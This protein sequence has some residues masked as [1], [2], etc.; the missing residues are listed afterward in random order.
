MTEESVSSKL[1]ELFDLYK[2]GAL[3]KE[4]YELLKSQIINQGVVQPINET[5]K[6]QEKDS[7]KVTKEE[8]VTT[9]PANFKN[10]HTDEPKELPKED[11]ITP[12]QEDIK[13]KQ[14]EANAPV[15]VP[16]AKSKKR[17]G[18]VILVIILLIALII[19]SLLLYK[20]LNSKLTIAKSGLP[21]QN[22]QTVKD[23]D[24]NVYHT[25]TIGSQVWIVENLRT[26]KYN[27]GTPIPL[28]TQNTSWRALTTPAYCW[29]KNDETTFKSTYGA[30]YNWHTVNTNELC[31]AGWHVP[32]DSEWTILTDYLINNDYGYLGS[33]DD[34]GKS[35]ASTEGWDSSSVLGSVGI[36]QASNNKSEFNALPSGIRFSNGEFRHSGQNAKWWSS[37]ETS[38]SKAQI[39]YLSW[40]DGIVSSF[41]NRKENGF[42]VRCV[43]DNSNL[44]NNSS[45]NIRQSKNESLISEGELEV[46]NSQVEGNKESINKIPDI[47]WSEV[48]V[49]ENANLAHITFGNSTF[50]SVTDNG[51]VTTNN[52]A[53]VSTDYGLNW[54]K[55]A[56]P[57]STNMS[58]VAYSPVN[59]YFVVSH[60][61]YES[62]RNYSYSNDK[63]NTWTEVKHDP[64]TYRYNLLRVKDYF[65][66]NLYNNT[67]DRSSDG[68]NWSHLT[69][70]GSNTTMVTTYSDKF[71]FYY[72]SGGNNFWTSRDGE[73]WTQRDTLGRYQFIAGNEIVLAYESASPI[74][75]L[76][77]SNDGINFNLI[78]IIPNVTSIQ[79]MKFIG[80]F[81]WATITVANDNSKKVIVSIDGTDW[82][83]LNT[84]STDATAYDISVG[85]E[86]NNMGDNFVI[87]SCSGG[88]FLRGSYNL[89]I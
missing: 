82:Q 18:R 83:V 43:K 14:P 19:V 84:P 13:N 86:S 27:D 36:V 12:Q 88:V 5:G 64:R 21:E 2:S 31:P 70:N 17:L 25:V 15:V 76:R 39:R 74:V 52:C 24:G 37:T 42:S 87:I 78:N 57:A 60:R 81:F 35:L 50:I 80:G 73:N 4:E 71:G 28:V 33:G 32:T 56:T 46:E 68:V 62:Q 38:E 59:D 72:A 6:E 16:D 1:T 22:E 67:C 79:Q 8:I 10:N 29:Y 54:V 77:R 89:E 23:I 65:F 63:G 61:C 41:S 51:C 3:T 53:Y 40:D 30:L 44:I 49:D 9:Q 58:G 26:T 7:E 85:S 75:T 34:I 66:S 69:F 55:K 47:S 20:S 11:I 48:H 45:Q